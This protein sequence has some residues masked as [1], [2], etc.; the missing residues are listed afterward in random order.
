[1]YID[2][3]CDDLVFFYCQKKLVET[4]SIEDRQKRREDFQHCVENTSSAF[5]KILAYN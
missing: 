3:Y 4:K 5:N 2:R 1:M